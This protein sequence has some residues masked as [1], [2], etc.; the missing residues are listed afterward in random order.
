M[1]KIPPAH[2]RF[3]D[4]PTCATWVANLDK[5][6]WSEVDFGLARSIAFAIPREVLNSDR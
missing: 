4:Y 2:E 3:H 5:D 1:A 6:H